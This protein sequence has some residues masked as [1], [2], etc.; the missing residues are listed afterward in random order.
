MWVSVFL[1]NF[2]LKRVLVEILLFVF[3]FLYIWKNT[4]VL[5]SWNI[6]H[7]DGWIDDLMGN[8]GGYIFLL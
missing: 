5:A 2:L 8:C 7:L 6:N 1:Y 3:T 4:E